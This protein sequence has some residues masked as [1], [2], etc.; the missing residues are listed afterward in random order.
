[1][2]AVENECKWLNIFKA[3]RR[4]RIIATGKIAM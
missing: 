2:V 1:M 4:I 3:E